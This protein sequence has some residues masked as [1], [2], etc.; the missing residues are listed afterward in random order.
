M[1]LRQRDSKLF[2]EMLN[3]LREVKHTAQDIMKFK[4][5]V[6]SNS[7]KYPLELP[8]FFVRNDEVSKFNNRVHFAMSGPRYSI[9]AHDSYCRTRF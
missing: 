8:Q 9:K 5:L 1:K 4:E 2:A 3:R 6:E 7:K